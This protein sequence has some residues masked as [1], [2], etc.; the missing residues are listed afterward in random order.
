MP[1]SCGGKA[2]RG[3]PCP[4]CG[5]V[6]FRAGADD[7]DTAFSPH[8]QNLAAGQQRRRMPFPG[9]VQVARCCPS[10]RGRII[11]FRLAKV[12]TS[13]PVL[14]SCDEHLTIGQHRRRM[15]MAAG[16][17]AARCHPCSSTRVIEFRAGETAGIIGEI[18]APR[19]E[20]LPVGQ[21]GC[22]VT[23][24]CGGEASCS[25]R[26]NRKAHSARYADG[27]SFY[28][29]AIRR[30]HGNPDRIRANSE[31]GSA[32]DDRRCRGVGNGRHDQHFGHAVGDARGV[33]GG[34]GR[35]PRAQGSGAEEQAREIGAGGGGARHGDGV[36][37]WGARG[38]LHHNC[39]SV[40]ANIEIGSAQNHYRRRAVGTGRRHCHCRHVI[41]DCR[42][43]HGPTGG[44]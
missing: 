18:G 3:D 6:E 11:H 21:Q 24:A 44:K 13:I 19:D 20:H 34:G 5:I 39:D 42:R 37:F 4:E 2:S 10:P 26:N 32:H 43:V 35:E 28:S 36:K 38:R 41:G 7:S 9:S 22:C 12:L 33:T 8:D 40:G 30:S 29:D 27:V 1:T 31:V 17:K 15:I 23:G 14:P 16:A 25:G